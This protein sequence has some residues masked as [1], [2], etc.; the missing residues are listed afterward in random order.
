MIILTEFWCVK[1]QT[2]RGE[3]DNARKRLRYELHWVSPEI[4]TCD[5]Q[6]PALG[7]SGRVNVGFF[8]LDNQELQMAALAYYL[9]SLDA[10]G[11]I[12]AGFTFHPDQSPLSE[13][14]QQT[15]ENFNNYHSFD[16]SK[17]NVPIFIISNEVEVAKSSEE[18]Q[19]DRYVWSEP[20][21][22][23]DDNSG[24]VSNSQGIIFSIQGAHFTC[25]APLENVSD[26]ISQSVQLFGDYSSSWD[27]KV[28]FNAPCLELPKEFYDA[29]AG[30]T[31]LRLNS[32]LGLSEMTA[33]ASSLPDLLFSLSFNG[34]QL[35]LPL[36]S[37]VL[38]ELSGSSSSN[39]ENST[40]FCIQRAGSMLQRGTAAFAAPTTSAAEV[41]RLQRL[42]GSTGIPVYNMIDSP[43]TFGAM[44]LEALGAVTVNE[45]TRRV[46]IRKPSAKVDYEQQTKASCLQSVSCIGGQEYVLHLNVCK[47]PDCSQFYFHSLDGETKYCVI[48]S[49]W[50]VMLI[51]T[52]TLLVIAELF[53]SLSLRR[54]VSQSQ[55]E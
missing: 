7:F 48:D 16:H 4:K 49:S 55:H 3:T 47:D 28:D 23:L 2:R 51:V 26:T 21:V 46:G 20:F 10:D 33:P 12:G 25:N 41:A 54:V 53:L 11:F 40:K 15:E 8:R 50:T 17:K 45:L 36:Q 30:W 24:D 31:G 37:L 39:E 1:M 19:V 6:T 22:P 18:E 14:I 43:I 52:T 5:V 32:R 27:V 44:V 35:A 38:P 42:H 9:G 34:V 29:L 13:T